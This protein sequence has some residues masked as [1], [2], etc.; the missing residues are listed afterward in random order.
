[1]KNASNSSATQSSPVLLN[2][3]LV[4]EATEGTRLGEATAEPVPSAGSHGT[5][6]TRSGPAPATDNAHMPAKVGVLGRLPGELLG[7][8]YGPFWLRR[9]KLGRRK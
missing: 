4:H 6:G 1:M 2:V 8:G 3:C 7:N 9:G 5:N